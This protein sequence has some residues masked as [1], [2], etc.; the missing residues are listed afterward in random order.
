[1]QT[2][3]DRKWTWQEFLGWTFGPRRLAQLADEADAASQRARY[4][5]DVLSDDTVRAQLV[6]TL[7]AVAREAERLEL[8]PQATLA[9]RLAR[10]MRDPDQP[11][12]MLAHVREGCDL[13]ARWTRDEIDR[14]AGAEPCRTAA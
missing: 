8:T 2:I 10:I 1:M 4:L 9:R 14:H 11:P 6:K 7:G 3:G 5:C 13:L 12:V